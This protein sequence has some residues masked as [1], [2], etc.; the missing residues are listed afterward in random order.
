MKIDEISLKI[1]MIN[2]LPL[3]HLI[4]LVFCCYKSTSIKAEVNIGK[5]IFLIK[6][7]LAYEYTNFL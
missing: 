1:N 2:I 7:E 4:V 3:T 6:F 5:K